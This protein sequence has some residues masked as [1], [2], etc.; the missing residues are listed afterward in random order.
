MLQVLLR[1]IITAIKSS[2]G[3]YWWIKMAPVIA[4]FRV[5]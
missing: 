4:Y 5:N 1:K 2:Y 3:M